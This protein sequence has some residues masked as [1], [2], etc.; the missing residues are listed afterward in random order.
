MPLSAAPIVLS[1]DRASDAA[2]AATSL[3]TVAT[4]VSLLGRHGIAPEAL[5]AG[6]GITP[7]CLTEPARLVTHAQELVVFANARRLL[8]DDTFGLRLGQ[9]LHISSYG[10]LGYTLLVSPTLRQALASAIRFPLLL[11]SYFRLR[12]EE[13]GDTARLVADGYHYR[14]D[15]HALNAEM[16]LSSMWTI[17]RDCTGLPLAPSAVTLAFRAP[18]HHA[19]Y[20][21]I[22]GQ[23]GT[24][25]ASENALI[26]PAEWLDRPQ[27]L[28]DPVSYHMALEHCERLEG[29]WAASQG[30]GFVARALRLVRTDPARYAQAPQLAAALHVSER[31]LRRRFAALGTSFQAVID[32]VRCE[33]AQHFLRHTALPVSAIAERLG[34]AEPA[35]F[36][37][38]FQRWTGRRPSDI[39]R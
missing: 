2:T 25:E 23:A 35:S 24:F 5:L 28:A 32:Q 27:P 7:A 19:L 16:C 8:G 6:S 38:A 14:A 39:R 22:F 1:P 18:A 31:T 26:F 3:H 11:G 12:V 29:E 4:T 21:D 36:R 33:E 37:H 34:F 9:S 10:L 17:A 20:A 15:L 30:S 13:K